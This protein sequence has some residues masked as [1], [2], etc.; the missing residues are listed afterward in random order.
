MRLGGIHAR[1][2]DSITGTAGALSLHALLQNAALRAG[3]DLSHARFTSGTGSSTQAAFSGLAIQG[4]GG[5]GAI[6]A[7]ASGSASYLTGDYTAWTVHLEGF[8]AVAG[9]PWLGTAALG[10]GG[11][12]SIAGEA[13]LVRTASLNARLLLGAATLEG[14][15][16]GTTSDTTRFAEAAAGVEWSRGPLRLGIAAGTRWG[17][18]ADDLLLQ[19]HAE[20]RVA[21]RV[22]LEA[23][24]GSYPR[25][26]TGFTSGRFV[27][28]GL[29]VALTAPAPSRS[30]RRVVVEPLA[31]GAQV[32]FEVPEA[33]AVAIA[34][35]W[36]QWRPDPLTRVAPGRWQIVLLLARGA[37]RFSLV[38]D[39]ERWIVPAGVPTLPDDFGGEVG[40]LLIQG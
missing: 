34:G 15:L 19:G 35:E 23:A 21:S 32:T 39:G 13:N 26:L 12:R 3:F 37:Y 27:N 20:L 40:V 1:Y 28:V 4:L 18:L 8:A 30:D 14:R 11:V 33:G 6:G 31:S 22:E 36:N 25:D 17:D 38:I 16:A 24:A 5:D 2:A 29:R 10:A 9:G 7:R